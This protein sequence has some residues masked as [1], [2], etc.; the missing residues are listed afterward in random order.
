MLVSIITALRLFGLT[1]FI[2]CSVVD[3]GDL[4]GQLASWISLRLSECKLPALT[5]ESSFN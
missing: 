3:Q 1:S 2:P 5:R 4:F